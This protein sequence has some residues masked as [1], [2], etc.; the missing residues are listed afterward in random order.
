MNLLD[1]PH[2]EHGKNVGICIKQ[3]LAMLHGG[4]MCMDRPVLI[5]MALISKITRFPVVGAQPKE[6]LEN[7]AC[8]KEIVEIV[9]DQFGNNR[10]N[11]G[12]VIKDINDF[13]MSFYNKLMDCK[14]KCIKKE[15]PTRVIVVV[16]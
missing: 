4:I 9:K 2:F 13:K 3:L 12:I 11:K 6:Y 5:D 8:E 14:W 1:I 10:G 7:K 16:V 15:A